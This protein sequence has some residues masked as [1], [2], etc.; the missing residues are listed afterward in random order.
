MASHLTGRIWA[1]ARD[2][3]PSQWRDLTG[4]PIT[5]Q[6]ART[7]AQSLRVDPQTRRRLRQHGRGPDASGSGQPK[8]PHDRDRPSPGDL[9]QAALKLAIHA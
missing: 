5:R 7:L 6:Q 3:R 4:Q 9:T 1:V 8:A 2:N